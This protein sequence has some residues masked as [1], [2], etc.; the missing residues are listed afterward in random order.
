MAAWGQIVGKRLFAW[1]KRLGLTQIALS[2][3]SGIP[4]GSIARI[5]GGYT[6]DVQTSTLVALAQAFGVTPDYLLGL[7]EEEEEQPR[8]RRRAMSRATT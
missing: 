8:R 6:D 5:E 2:A 3:M 1:R 7:V 4:Q